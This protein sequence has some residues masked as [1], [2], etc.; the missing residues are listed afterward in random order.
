MLM[1]Q[2]VGLHTTVNMVLYLKSTCPFFLVGHFVSETHLV[3][4]GDRWITY[5]DE[6]VKMSDDHDDLQRERS[7]SI[8][9]YERQ[10]DPA[11]PLN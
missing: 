4:A 2:G 1:L 5:D 11:L 3:G 10:V 8:L 9:F 6:K 7:A